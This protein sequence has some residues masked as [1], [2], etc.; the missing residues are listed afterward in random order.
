MLIE[1]AAIGATSELVG[2][3]APRSYLACLGAYQAME[4]GRE[5]VGVVSC[6]GA[7]TWSVSWHGSQWVV[8]WMSGTCVACVSHAG[9]ATMTRRGGSSGV[10]RHVS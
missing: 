8:Y 1:I 7:A 4:G 3:C 9:Y 5:G 2:T 10:P 6:H